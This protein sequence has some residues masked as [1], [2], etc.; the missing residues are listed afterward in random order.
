V[1]LLGLK[2]N[3]NPEQIG[4]FDTLA[5]RTGAPDGS[6]SKKQSGVSVVNRAHSETARYRD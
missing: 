4:L 6:E 3:P 2:L 5:S 1:G